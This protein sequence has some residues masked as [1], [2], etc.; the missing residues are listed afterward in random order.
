MDTL[1]IPQDRLNRHGRRGEIAMARKQPMTDLKY[2]ASEHS[3]LTSR[4]RQE[5]LAYRIAKVK[6]NWPV[7][8]AFQK[9]HPKLR[10]QFAI[11]NKNL[12]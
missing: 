6:R 11:E 2:K 8:K 1:T 5:G 3:E 10:K 9:K 12:K 7:I 4:M